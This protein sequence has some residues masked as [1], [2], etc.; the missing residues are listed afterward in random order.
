MRELIA[1]LVMELILEIIS[2]DQL[3]T[4]ENSIANF[5]EVFQ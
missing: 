2:M 1:H 4:H 5:I 3:Y